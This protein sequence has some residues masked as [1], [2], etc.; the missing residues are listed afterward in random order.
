MYR[1]GQVKSK[2]RAK[3]Q[4]YFSSIVETLKSV[5]R[6]GCYATG[7]VFPMPMPSISL[8]SAPDDIFGLPFAECQVN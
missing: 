1:G 8:D 2:P 4:P 5:K 7:G 3:P 6:P